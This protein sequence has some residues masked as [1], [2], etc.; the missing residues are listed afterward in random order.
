MNK[1]E[2][3]KSLRF[4][5]LLASVA[6]EIVML[7]LLVANSVRLIQTSLNE[8]GLTRAEEIRPL[9]NA[10][11]SGPL[12]QRDYGT[13]QEI[14]NEIQSANGIAYLAVYDNNGKLIAANGWNTQRTIPE[15]D[16]SLDVDDGFFDTQTNI[17]ISGQKYGMLRYGL[18]TEFLSSAKSRLLQQSLLIASIEIGLSVLLLA[19][20]GYWL[21]RHLVL[22]TRASEEVASGNF[23]IQLPVNTEDEIGQ[24]SHAFNTMSATINNRIKALSES[25]AKFHAIADFTYGWESWLGPDGQLV[26]V[27]PS[28][29]RITGY[30]IDE[31]M[32]MKDFPS[33]M[34]VAEDAER[35]QLA[36][37]AALH[38][39]SKGE[40]FEFQLRRKNGHVIWLVVFW[41]PIYGAKGE[42][43]GIRTSMLDITDRKESEM[44]LHN[45]MAELRHA[46]EA[47]RLYLGNMEDERARLVA[48]LAAM[49][50]G[51]LFVNA[52]N[53]VMYYNPTFLRI[54]MIAEDIT[55]TGKAAEE[56][57]KYSGN[58][59]ARPDHFS[60]HILSVLE[61]HE[62][63][64]SFE[65]SMA[66]GRIITQLSYPVRD[67][68]GR[69]IGRLWIYED[70][71]RERQTAEQLIY[72]AERDALTGLFNR[73]R[74]QD[75]LTRLLA[76]AERHHTKGA[77]I[78]FDL[79]EFKY[80]N[81]TFGHRA[82]DTMLI[83]IAGEVG[84]LVRR[85]EILSRLG[86]DEFALLMP[87]AT[88]K[89]AEALAERVVRAISQIPFRFEGQNFRLTTSLGIALY[90]EHA[91]ST[92]ELIAHADAA[93]Y[94]AKEA[95]KNAWRKYRPDLDT[96]REMLTRLTWN[97]R[98]ASAFEKNLLRL[99]YQGVYHA[100]NGEI[101]HL[102]VLVRM[103]DE[104]DHER[105][106]MPGH[107]IPHAEKSGQILELDR[108]VV[109]ESIALLAKSENIPSLAINIS[110]RS[111]DEPTLPHYIAEQ[112]KLFKVKPHRLL[113]ELTETSAVSD[114]QD[115]ERFIEALHKTGC[116]T[117]LDDF[118][119]GFSSFA[120]LKHLK[121]DVLKIDG[122]FIRDL[123]NERDNQVFV[124]SIVDVARGLGKKT[125]AEFVENAEILEMLRRLGVDMVQ[126]YHL[127]KP[128]EHHPEIAKG[129][130]AG[131]RTED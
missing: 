65:I 78:F 10:A 45:T 69:F 72:L 43:L 70:I 125:V 116:T 7:T 51:I 58:V 52:E 124:K 30:S 54:W 49:N 87:D 59:L 50:M 48:L 31:C 102:E 17:S 35:V 33:S 41:Q 130:G 8:Q 63:S 32:A 56:V 12:A 98:I 82:G 88:E 3:G 55:L 24:L 96:S 122:L 9:L 77:L 21:T 1:P 103:V 19:L 90:P 131:L 117:C 86:G 42:S 118:G 123:T 79:D 38:G 44:M 73:R 74:L 23:S 91:A 94:Q 47:R 127:D 92:E 126:G 27:N 81:D 61:T 14:L 28:V 129:L 46:D 18:S 66:D 26:W 40:Y 16:T 4:R 93:M 106:I 113:I 104:Q 120:Y 108:W 114:L 64:D 25:E 105:L 112:L 34:A 2:F 13:L 53:Q 84:A 95:G 20:I 68:E 75:E 6:V 99:H 36:C 83:R 85:N 97:D 15:L 115:A 107:F 111:F 29:E 60:K 80:F 11:L 110:G 119:T 62:V 109:R 39:S 57:L 67:Q 100:A 101:A 121:A 5:L 89:E 128:Q 37:R 76:I 71:T 22:L